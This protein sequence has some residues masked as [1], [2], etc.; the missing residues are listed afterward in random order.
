MK[1]D[2]ALRAVAMLAIVAAYAVFLNFGQSMRTLVFVVVAV[3]TLA[4]PEFVD[5]LPFGPSKD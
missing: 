2:H 1:W 4:M 5:R 3:G